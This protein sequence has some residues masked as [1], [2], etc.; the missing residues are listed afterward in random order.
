M[1]STELIETASFGLPVTMYE[2]IKVSM[3]PTTL[4]DIDLSTLML[5]VC[6]LTGDF[7]RIKSIMAANIY[8]IHRISRILK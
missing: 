7:S 2:I 4:H 1:T 5:L 3:V 6:P 8:L